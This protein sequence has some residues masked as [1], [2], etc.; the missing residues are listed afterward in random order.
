ME[1]A[2]Q[3]VE[4][5]ARSSYGRLLAYLSSRTRDV[6]GAEDAL[7]EALLAALHSWPRDGVPRKP[8]AWL[9]T[10]AR[11]RLIDQARHARVRTEHAES[12]RLLSD[13]SQRAGPEDGF[14]DE[15]LKLFFVC[16][17]PAIDPAL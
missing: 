10:A 14:P 9:L 3:T 2:R 17:H 6:A 15:R 8:E 7:G 13:E 5:V 11:N 1:E 16:A 12:I 4:A